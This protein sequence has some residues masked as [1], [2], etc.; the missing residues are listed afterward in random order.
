MIVNWKGARILS[1][2]VINPEMK[3]IEATHGTTGGGIQVSIIP[4]YNEVLDVYWPG[5]IDSLNRYI[6]AGVL[7]LFGK[8]QT[9][10]EGDDDYISDEDSEEK[11]KPI[12]KYLGQPLRRLQP[13]KARIAVTNCFN[14]QSLELWLNGTDDYEAESRDETRV[15]IKEQIEKINSGNKDGVGVAKQ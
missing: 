5:V 4:G 7:D 13:K 14:M 15:L 12:I 9:V 2:P 10:E 3:E 6:E 11:G 1:V 8:R